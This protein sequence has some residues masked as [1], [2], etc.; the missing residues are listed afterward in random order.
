MKFTKHGIEIA[1]LELLALAG[2]CGS[3]DVDRAEK[4]AVVF[5][6]AGAR[7]YAT[8]GHTAV[9]AAATVE[10]VPAWRHCAVGGKLAA[11]VARAADRKLPEIV[12]ATEDEGKRWTALLPGNRQRFDVLPPADWQPLGASFLAMFVP[13]EGREHGVAMASFNPALIARLPPVIDAVAQRE[14]LSA[15]NNRVDAVWHW[16]SAP[17]NALLVRVLP[18]PEWRVLIMP[19][20]SDYVD[21]WIKAPRRSEP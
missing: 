4:R 11:R 3:E 9:L 20:R 19:G 6:A 5:D 1:K 17:M 2:F 12:F 10:G 14:G 8:D 15:R 7:A 16:P 13:D 18:A 21:A